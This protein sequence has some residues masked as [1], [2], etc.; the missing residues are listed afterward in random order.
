MTYRIEF[1]AMVKVHLRALTARERTMV[2][3]AIER[4]LV[5]EPLVATRNRKPLDTNPIAPW[6]LRIGALRVFYDAS[7]N[8]TKV[9]RILAVG[10]KRGAVLRIGRQEMKL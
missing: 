3:D 4:Q 9:V 6:E 7:D 1:A 2:F 10:V 5:H 8:R